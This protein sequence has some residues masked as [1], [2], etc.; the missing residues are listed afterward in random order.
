MPGVLC[1]KA[2]FLL[3]LLLCSVLWLYSVRI[4]GSDLLNFHV[5]I[6][7]LQNQVESSIVDI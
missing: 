7:G 1:T 2:F 4:Y 3:L 5:E 6:S